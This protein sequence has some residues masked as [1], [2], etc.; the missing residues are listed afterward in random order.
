LAAVAEAVLARVWQPL[1]LVVVAAAVVVQ[2]VVAVAH[3]TL[4]SHSVEGNP[5]VGRQP[6]HLPLSTPS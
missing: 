2:V 4:Q 5:R 1:A 6:R 3:Q